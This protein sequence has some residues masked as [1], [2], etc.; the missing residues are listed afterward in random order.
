MTKQK[1]KK[2]QRIVIFVEGDT[3]E[4]FFK[5][6]LEYYKPVSKMELTPCE[7]CNLKGEN[8]NAKLCALYSKARRTYSKGYATREMIKALNFDRII[9]KRMAV[10]KEL[11]EVLGVKT[12]LKLTIRIH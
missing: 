4:V 1:G 3:D 6:M 5:E 10:L 7:I 11:E 2:A 8:G 9:A 12:E